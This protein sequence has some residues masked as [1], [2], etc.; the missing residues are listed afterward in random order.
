[1]ILDVMKDWP[2]AASITNRKKGSTG[3]DGGDRRR[4]SDSLYR[5][6]DRNSAIEFRPCDKSAIRL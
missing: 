2:G 1:M 6:L 5:F 3:E 4:G